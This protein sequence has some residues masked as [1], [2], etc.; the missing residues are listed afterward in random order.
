MPEDLRFFEQLRVWMQAF[1]PA[2]RDRTYQQKFAPLGLFAADSPYGEGD[3]ELTASLRAGLVVG[4]ETME[5][6]LRN[7]DAPKQNGWDVAYHSF[8]YNLDFFELGT[9]DEPRWKLADDPSRYLKRALAARGGLWGNHGYEAAYAMVYVDGDGNALDGSNTYELR[10]AQPPP[11]GAF[12][13]VTMYDTPDFYP[14]RQPDRA[15]TRSAIARPDCGPTDDGSLTIVMQA[16]EPA[17]GER[18]A[19]WLPTPRRRLP[20]DPAHVRA[21]RVGIR[22]RLPAAADHEG[23]LT[24]VTPRGRRARARRRDRRATRPQ[25]RVDRP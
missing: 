3:S 4:R 9:L 16:D 13:S 18:R 23:Q 11:C 17:D 6:A 24:R 7:S 20:A 15:G 2:E 19:N 5:R 21:R 25:V 12:W 22:R 10:F 8:D 1:P 14:R